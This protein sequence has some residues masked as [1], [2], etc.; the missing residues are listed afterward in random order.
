MTKP[1]EG[2]DRARNGSEPGQFTDG[3]Q[4]TYFIVFNADHI[5]PIAIIEYTIKL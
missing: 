4:G 2:F 5:L 1:D 3:I